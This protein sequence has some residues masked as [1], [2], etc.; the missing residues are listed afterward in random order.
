MCA[1]LEVGLR[2]RKHA[3]NHDQRDGCALIVGDVEEGVGALAIDDFGAED[4]GA[5]EGSSY[6]DIEGRRVLGGGNAFFGGILRGLEGVREFNEYHR[7]PRRL[8][9][10]GWIGGGIHV[11]HWQL[12]HQW[13][14][15]PAGQGQK[16]GRKP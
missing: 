7:E 9:A 14:V 13:C 6:G 8:R 10:R 3:T 5:G 12:R 15:E 4:L 2:T 1:S 11:R 16:S